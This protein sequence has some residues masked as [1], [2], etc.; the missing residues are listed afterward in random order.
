LLSFNPFATL[1]KFARE[2]LAAANTAMASEDESTAVNAQIVL[3]AASGRTFDLPN[4][5]VD[6]IAVLT[7]GPET[8]RTQRRIRLHH[9]HR[10]GDNS[11]TGAAGRASLVAS[12]PEEVDAHAQEIVVHGAGARFRHIDEF[13]GSYD[14]LQYPVLFQLGKRG[15]DL[16]NDMPLNSFVKYLLFE[17]DG[18]FSHL[19][20]ADRLFQV[21]FVDQFAKIEQQRLR[22]IKDNQ[23]RLR[24]D[25]YQN[26]ADAVARQR[27]VASIGIR[28]ILPSTFTGSRRDMLGRY[29][30]A[31]A[32]V[33]RFGKPDLFV[34]VTCNPSWPEIAQ[35]LASQQD[36]MGFKRAP[37]DRMDIIVRVFRQKLAEIEKDIRDN[38][39]LGLVVAYVRVVEFQKRGLPHTP[40]S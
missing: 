40:T 24:Q 31:M 10:Q 28:S 38:G 20:A 34:T 35:Y 27:S 11:A 13:H 8:N 3:K 4:D 36:E 12:Q 1:Y 19:H 14:P 18:V 29:H 7:Q 32:I 21:F 6:E 39:V 37:S 22:L 30:D 5:G 15:W 33:R 9:R 26:F 25:T 16:G 17:R 2:I 23:A